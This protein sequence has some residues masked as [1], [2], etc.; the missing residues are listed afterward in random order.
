MQTG[1][2]S[3][4]SKHNLVNVTGTVLTPIVLALVMLLNF[5]KLYVTHHVS[6]HDYFRDC[7]L[8]N[9]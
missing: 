1:Y 7:N 5:A 9:Y 6:A 8:F 3:I 2:C 4:Q